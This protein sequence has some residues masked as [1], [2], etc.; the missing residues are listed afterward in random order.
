LELFYQASTGLEN[1]FLKMSV[2]K[3]FQNSRDLQKY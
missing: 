2:K 1:E 3:Y